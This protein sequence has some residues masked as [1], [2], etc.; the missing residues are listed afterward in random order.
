MDSLDIELKTVVKEAS[1]TSKEPNNTQDDTQE[2]AKLNLNAT[3]KYL[4]A[5]SNKKAPSGKGYMEI[6]RRI[7]GENIDIT[8]PGRDEGFFSKIFSFLKRK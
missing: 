2:V 3:S 7:L 6:A 5:V 1:V 4:S 8:I